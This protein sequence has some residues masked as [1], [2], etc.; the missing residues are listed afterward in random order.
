MGPGTTDSAELI[1][2]IK[3]RA[4][5]RTETDRAHRGG[6]GVEDVTAKARTR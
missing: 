3:L 1:V 4:T 6:F 5:F 2:G